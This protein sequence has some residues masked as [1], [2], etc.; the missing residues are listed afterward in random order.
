MSPYERTP[1]AVPI[2]DAGPVGARSGDARPSGWTAGRVAAIVGGVL[3]SLVSLCL[4]VGAGFGVWADLAQREGGYVTTGVRSFSSPG[5]A[6]STEPTKLGSAGVGW[7][8]APALLGKVRIRVTPVGPRQP[9]F[10]G[11]GPS[12]AVERYLTGAAHTRIVDFWGSGV[13]TVGG[14]RPAPPPGA[15]PFWVASTSGS[16]PRSLIWDPEDGSWSV[17]V[18]NA[19]GRPGIAVRA[20]L[21]ARMPALIWIALASLAL[22]A[23][24]MA[25]AALLIVGA[26]RRRR[27]TRLTTTSPTRGGTRDGAH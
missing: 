14:G 13:E 5:V 10:V 9:V 25:C 2:T 18:M 12:D 4:L 24:F 15:R 7:L 21:G 16:G 6:L 11:I 3:L 17:V 23:I 26:I 22:G 20:D 27:V 19:D 1:A 8:Y